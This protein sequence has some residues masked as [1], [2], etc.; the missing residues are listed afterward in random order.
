MDAFDIAVD[1]FR[2]GQPTHMLQDAVLDYFESKGHPTP[3]STPGTMEGYVHSL[4]H[5]VGLNIHERPS[6]THVQ[7]TDI[8]QAGNVVSIEPGLYYPERG[9]GVRIEDLCYVDESG[10]LVHLTDFHKDLVLPL[11]G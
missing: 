5:G 9:Y 4:G 3:R 10:Q 7:K 8:F 2:V 6:I 1:S 11:R